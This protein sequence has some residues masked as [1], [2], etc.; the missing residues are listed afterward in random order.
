M[1]LFS[2]PAS[3]FV[4]KVVVAL[5]ETGQ[6]GAVEIVPVTISP[7]APG[8]TVPAH[9]PLGKIPALALDDGRTLFDSRT[10]TRYIDSLAPGT[11]YPE[12]P[13]LWE[14]LVLESL[15]DGIM[16]AAVSMAYEGRLRPENMRFEP[17]LDAQWLKIDRALT[18]IETRH[19]GQL[20]AR[21][22]IAVL[23]VAIALEY[24]DFRHDA[25][26]W[27]A[28]HAT[29]AAWHEGIAGRDSLAATRPKV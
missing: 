24:V 5:H 26:N 21:P 4:R 12:A 3:P 14:A 19:M 11:L 7:I 18:A 9:N 28:N 6:L 2:A 22:D 27:R 8:D 15:A 10:I 16:D 23:A 17:W 29:L 20:N 1:K 25:R 13:D